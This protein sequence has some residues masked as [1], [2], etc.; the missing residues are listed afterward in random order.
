MW[1]FHSTAYFWARVSPTPADGIQS[2]EDLT[3]AAPA[4]SQLE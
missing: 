1:D 2:N 3:A 4:L